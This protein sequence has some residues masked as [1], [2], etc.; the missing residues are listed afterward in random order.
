MSFL[1]DVLPIAER[2]I[3][4]SQL[5]GFSYKCLCSSCAETPTLGDMFMFYERNREKKEKKRVRKRKRKRESYS[6]SSIR[7]LI[8]L[9]LRILIALSV[10]YI[11]FAD[12]QSCCYSKSVTKYS[13]FSSSVLFVRTSFVGTLGWHIVYPVYQPIAVYQ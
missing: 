7:I 2:H 4:S 10:K 13:V 1:S 9:F 11:A 12:V 6:A 3:E 8:R 5:F